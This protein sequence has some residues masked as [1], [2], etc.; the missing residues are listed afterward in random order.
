MRVVTL[1]T[2]LIRGGAQRIALETAAFLNEAGVDAP[3]WCG[4]ETGSEGSLHEEA[5][6]RGVPVRIFPD[7]VRAIDP[8]RDVRAAR[9][10]RRA[11]REARPDWVHTHSSKAG[12]L[13]RRA[14][15]AAGVRRIAH[16]VHGWGFT[17]DS[18]WVLR[19]L[20]IALERAAARAVLSADAGR[21]FFV[22]PTDLEEGSRLGILPRGAGTL[23]PPGIDLRPFR[24]AGRLAAERA[25]IRREA[26]WGPETPVAGVFGRLAPQKDPGTALLALARA[27][28]SHPD[29]RVLVVG[30]GPL[31]PLLRARADA[32]PNLAG[33]VRWAGLQA[34]P[35]PWLAA[36]DLLVVASRWEGRPL[37]V[38][39]GMA[40]GLPI[41]AT[42][43]PGL[44]AL[45]LEVDA[46][47]NGEAS[48]G[49]GGVLTLAPPGDADAFARCILALASDGALRRALG[50][51]AR[52]AALARFGLEPMLQRLLAEYRQGLDRDLEQRHEA[53]AQP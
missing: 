35:V 44:R 32:D 21:T 50:S 12:I 7:L 46:T 13:G 29:L 24:D 4:P 33:R 37:S 25:R 53:H 16:K 36:M 5:A 3:L 11:L 40:A 43:I 47:G 9:A 42:D 31:A 8:R 17:P 51:A 2:R 49:E 6:A 20:F 45:A 18:P 1:I 23:L 28:R 38:L 30:D 19:R 34:D 27:A 41:V 22:S 10:L 48:R 39:E 52:E 14:A 26:G 15:R